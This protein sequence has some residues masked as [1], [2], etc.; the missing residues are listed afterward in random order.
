MSWSGCITELTPGFSLTEATYDIL[1]VVVD[2]E[3]VEFEWLESSGKFQAS[4]RRKETN[5]NE[6]W[7]GELLRLAVEDTGTIW[8][9]RYDL[10]NGGLVFIGNWLFGEDDGIYLVEIFQQ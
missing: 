8:M 9:V 2:D 4:L 7:S 10:A 3:V 1:H 6:L 5:G